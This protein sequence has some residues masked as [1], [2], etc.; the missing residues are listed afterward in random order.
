MSVL[1]VGGGCG[2]FTSALT[3]H[4]AGIPIQLITREKSFGSANAR[5]VV[6]AGSAV[7]ILD[8]LGIGTLF[9]SYGTPITHGTV[10]NERGSK[11]FNL[12]VPRTVG[13]C[14]VVP[15]PYLQQLFVEALPSNSVAF[16][17]R[18]RAI[19]SHPNVDFVAAELTHSSELRRHGM[20]PAS[21]S[22]TSR[23]DANLVIGADGLASAVRGAIS[24]PM[25]TT[26]Y[27]SC[28]N[29]VAITS[30]TDKYPMHSF[31]EIWGSA[32]PDVAESDRPRFGYVR[33]SKN[34]VAWRAV[35]PS[36]S[37]LRPFRSKLRDLFN[38]FPSRIQELLSRTSEREIFRRQ[39]R[40]LW[41]DSSIW[42]DH[43]SYRIALVGEAGRA[44]ELGTLHHGKCGTSTS[45]KANY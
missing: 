34:A 45:L 25:L 6:V 39:L 41:N 12:D 44:G 19:H 27:T 10:E 16:S 35:F 15:R 21:R 36:T 5:H 11:L 4:R 30:D 31:C 26:S 33:T 40:T 42:I 7:R 29:A 14:W 22:A 38:K 2:G 13:E 8:R 20:Y 3:L 9:R 24:R 28:W 17:T 43:D 32:S 1:I 37:V 18:L 23:I